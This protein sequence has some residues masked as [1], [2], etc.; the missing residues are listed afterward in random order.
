MTLV[1]KEHK[2]QEEHFSRGVADHK[3]QGAAAETH[4]Q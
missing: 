2:Q 4:Q 3:P 1:T